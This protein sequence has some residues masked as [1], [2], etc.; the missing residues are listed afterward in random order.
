MGTNVLKN[1]IRLLLREQISQQ[2]YH[3]KSL[4][5]SLEFSFLK[6]GDILYHGVTLP[7]LSA[8]LFLHRCLSSSPPDL[9]SLCLICLALCQAAQ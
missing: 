1:L 7:S 2:K 9:F 4:Q 8:S 5:K 3:N 6:H